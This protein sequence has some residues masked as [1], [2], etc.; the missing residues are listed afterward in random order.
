MRR[1]FAAFFAIV[2]L[3]LGA[4]AV[5][6][7]GTV[8]EVTASVEAATPI[9]A[10]VRRRMETTVSAIGAQLLAGRRIA[11]V[12][13]ARAQ[14]EAIIHEVFDKVL[15]GYSVEQVS[16]AVGEVSRVDVRLAPWADVIHA[17]H[18]KVA[19]EGMPTPV[20]EMARRDLADVGSVFGAG[21]NGLPVAASDWTNGVLKRSLQQYMDEHL[22][23]FRAD[24]DRCPWPAKLVS[25]DFRLG[26]RW[27]SVRQEDVGLE[28]GDPWAAGFLESLQTKIGEDLKELGAEDVTYFGFLD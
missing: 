12:E 24:F 8:D 27:Y 13:T 5:Q 22:P 21:M 4:S 2:L 1:V 23:E 7:A 26:W 19:V 17:V 18:V 28:E 10:I 11:D 25:I 9:P 6:A 15:V 20:E 16:L 3:L 14:Q